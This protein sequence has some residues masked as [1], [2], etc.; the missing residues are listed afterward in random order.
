MLVTAKEQTAFRF[1][2]ELISLMKQRSK[3]L[4]ISVNTYVTNLITRDLEE[5]KTLPKIDL[6]ETLDEDI[7]RLSGIISCPSQ[8]ELDA[9]ERL[10]RIWCR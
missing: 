10:K 5:S 2:P 4:N 9:D 7:M 1:A 6:P 3:S 8:E